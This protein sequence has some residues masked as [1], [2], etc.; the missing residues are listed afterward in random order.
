MPTRTLSH[1]GFAAVE[2]TTPALRLV[3][4]HG[5]GPRIAWL[6]RPAG[7]NLLQWEENSPLQ[8]AR[9]SEAKR[10]WHM[11]GGH[12]V[13]TARM[14][15][16]EDEQTYAND[17]APGTCTAT[18]DGFTV[19]GALCEETRTQRS[20]SV[21]VLRD[22][23]LEVVNRIVNRG[24][25][26]LGCGLWAI[27]C[28]RPGPH[29]RYVVP[30]GDGSDWD[31][32]TITVFRCWAGHGTGTFRDDQGELTDDAYVL[33]PRGRETK[34]MVQTPAGAIAM[35]DPARDLTFAIS[36]PWQR[37]APYP[38]NANIAMYVSPQ[39]FLV[40][41]ETMGPHTVLKSG[42]VLEHRQEWTLAQG[43]I[44]LTGAAVRA[45]TA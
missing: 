15:A 10:P 16:D 34:R 8:Y 5:T 3:A 25:M 23:R 7:D 39:N 17:D 33:T 41:M 1:A 6:S 21:R 27:T 31:T 13:W 20:I 19:T 35:I 24:N 29:T 40:E 45:F 30:L 11:R 44:P 43:A 14:G 26:L 42:E 36:A 38:A 22:D 12:R 28:S 37:G 9:E 4:V 2:L 18:V 32:A